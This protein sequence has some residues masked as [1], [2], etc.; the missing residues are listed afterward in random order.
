MSSSSGN[1]QFARKL[2]EFDLDENPVAKKSWRPW[3]RTLAGFGFWAQGFLHIVVGTLA[4][5]LALGMGGEAESLG[6]ALQEIAGHAFGGVLLGLLALGF[7][8]LAGWRVVQAVWD[9]DEIG[10]HLTGLA[11]RV[12]LLFIGG[13]HLAL[14]GRAIWILWQG[15]GG[16]DAGSE[17]ERVNAA[18]GWLLQQPWGQVLVGLVGVIIVAIAVANIVRAVNARFRENYARERMSRRIQFVT[19]LLGRLGFA[20]RA[21]LLLTAATLFFRAAWH[22]SAEQTGG[23]AK[24]METLLQQP[25]GT[26][27]LAATGGGLIAY[28]LFHWSMIRY[29]GFKATD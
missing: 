3:I 23:M 9:P 15:A 2:A 25:F 18:T 29:R 17:N 22:A 1:S 5:L 26:A 14:A 6:S 7:I 10:H 24:S 21:L 8:S 12:G 28:G 19:T 27:L 20:A 11:L 4:T 16:T 13:L